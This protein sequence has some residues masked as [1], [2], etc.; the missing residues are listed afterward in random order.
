M[1]L[2]RTSGLSR[3]YASASKSGGSFVSMPS[4]DPLQS[5]GVLVPPLHVPFGGK[6]DRFRRLLVERLDRARGRPDDQRV[7]GKLLALGNERAG[8]DQRV[9]ADLGAV[10]HD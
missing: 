10:E 2:R 4:T 6:R 7:V 5:L 8:A 3:R 1:P 9:L